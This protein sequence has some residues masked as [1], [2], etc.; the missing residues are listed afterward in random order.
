MLANGILILKKRF[1]LKKNLQSKES[2]Q[3]IIITID[4]E[5][6]IKCTN[7]E[8]NTQRVSFKCVPTPTHK[9]QRQCHIYSH[10][11]AI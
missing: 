10:M 2:T 4:R 1:N 6:R 3:P 11:T 7:H 8:C 9:Q 5:M